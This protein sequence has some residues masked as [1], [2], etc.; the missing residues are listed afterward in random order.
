M[1]RS[2]INVEEK[3]II[4][5]LLDKY[6]RSQHLINPHLF[7]R[8]V[9]LRIEN[10]ELPE[11][12]YENSE[13]KDKYN[14]AS[15]RLEK[16]KLISIEWVKGIKRIDRLILNLKNLDNAYDFVGRIH[17]SKEVEAFCNI[18]ENGLID[19]KTEWIVSWRNDVCDKMRRT[20][21]FDSDLK[22][23]K[24]FI[25]KLVKAFREY[26]LLNDDITMRAFSS[27]C[28]GNTKTFE[29]EIRDTF[30]KIADKYDLTFQN[31]CED[32]DLNVR[33]KLAYFGIYARPEI[34]EFSGDL[35]LVTENGTIDFSVLGN[36]GAA[37]RSTV[38][39]MIK[40][41]DMSNIDKVIF[42]ENKT[43]YDE[44]ISSENSNSRLIIYHGGFMSS[45]KQKFI[46]K[47]YENCKKNTE[48]EF[49]ADI[50]LGGFEMFYKLKEIIPSLKPLNMSAEDV[51]KYHSYGLIRKEKYLYKLK[52]AKINDKYSIFNDVIDMILKFG[53]T[54]EQ[55]TFLLK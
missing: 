32:S 4:N 1:A 42:I 15:E 18:I 55:E 20:L 54:I 27:K 31:V 19:I 17:P 34:Y 25:T 29:K 39:P 7:N 46:S 6:E 14:L 33:D 10:N 36:C 37:V 24:D 26:D 30:L 23:G 13:I 5:R 44:Y 16:N 40:T 53:V 3:I 22:K 45:Q 38:L 47:V 50:D 8:R 48:F 51:N 35:L 12:N 49:W 52:Q 41:F 43:N 11:Y 2:L 21:K 28:Y 9:M